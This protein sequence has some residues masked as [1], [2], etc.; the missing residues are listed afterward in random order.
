M[1]ISNRDWPN[2]DQ[3]NISYRQPCSF[4]IVNLLTWQN[5]PEGGYDEKSWE[6]ACNWLMVTSFGDNNWPS[7]PGVWFCSLTKLKKKIINRRQSKKPPSLQLRGLIT[8]T[9]TNLTV[10]KEHFDTHFQWKGCGTQHS[11]WSGTLGVKYNQF[12]P[13]WMHS[14]SQRLQSFWASTSKMLWHMATAAI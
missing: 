7:G 13:R 6:M 14:Y 4:W 1:C 11:Q 5:A 3:I 10:L 2:F 9:S 12:G 8:A